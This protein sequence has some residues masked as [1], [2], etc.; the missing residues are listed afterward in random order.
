MP[1]QSDLIYIGPI[2]LT[3]R[4]YLS[5]VVFTCKWT[6]FYLTDVMNTGKKMIVI[7]Q[8][9][10]FFIITDCFWSYNVI[11]ICKLGCTPNKTYELII[12]QW[13]NTLFPVT[14]FLEEL[15]SCES[16]STFSRFIS[17]EYY[18][19]SNSNY[20]LNNSMKKSW[21]CYIWYNFHHLNWKKENYF[22]LDKFKKA[23]DYKLKI[24]HNL[25]RFNF[26][27]LLR[28]RS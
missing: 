5:L 2:L 21:N 12:I 11:T 4:E 27:M 6:R 14:N 1:S 18:F 13:P 8:F 23:K 24:L 26:S 16:K 10:S 22:I 25:A 20:C 7:F 9:F 15:F 19:G 28:I 3:D 17:K